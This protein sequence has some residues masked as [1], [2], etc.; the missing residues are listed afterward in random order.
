MKQAVEVFSK[1]KDGQAQEKALIRGLTD[2]EMVAI[3]IGE[4]K[5]N[6]PGLQVIIRNS[7]R[8]AQRGQKK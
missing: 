5:V 1:L 6:T 2:P 8:G 7:K 4:V 3:M